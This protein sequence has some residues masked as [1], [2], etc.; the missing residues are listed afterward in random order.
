MKLE[1]AADVN[2]YFNVIVE[3][4]SWGFFTFLYAQVMLFLL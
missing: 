3:D 1:K 4:S 2:R